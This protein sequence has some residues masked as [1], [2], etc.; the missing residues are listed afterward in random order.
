[1]FVNQGLTRGKKSMYLV[2]VNSPMCSTSDYLT[3]S[4]KIHPESKKKKR[5]KSLHELAT[6]PGSTLPP[7]SVS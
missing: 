1:M 5:K 3:F 2:K 6:C 7:P 4:D